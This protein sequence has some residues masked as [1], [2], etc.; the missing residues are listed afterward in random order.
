MEFPFFI[1]SVVPV[2]EDGYSV[3][4]SKTC[5]E[6]QRSNHIIFNPTMPIYKS[7]TVSNNL[8]DIINRMGANSSKAQK[9]PVPITSFQ[10]LIGTNQ[11]LYLHSQ[12]KKVI[13]LLKVGERK[14]FHMDLGGKC[15]EIYPLCVLDFYIHE[16]I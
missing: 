15:S 14:L 9:I 13:G 16:S 1:S 11:R 3:I 12:G 5:L 8:A 4:T 10:K 7:K 6:C 2:D